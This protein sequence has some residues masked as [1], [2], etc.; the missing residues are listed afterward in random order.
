[1]DFD[2]DQ[3]LSPEEAADWLKLPA[4]GYDVATLL[5]WAKDGEIECIHIGKKVAFLREHL[6]RFVRRGT[7]PEPLQ[8]LRKCN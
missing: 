8:R 4:L 6:V 2:P 1:M 7:A 3:P 5:R